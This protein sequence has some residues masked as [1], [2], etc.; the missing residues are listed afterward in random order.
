MK[1]ILCL[2]LLLYLLVSYLP[3]PKPLE[4]S[5]QKP[6]DTC[7]WD[8]WPQPFTT[9]L[10]SVCVHWSVDSRGALVGKLP[11]GSRWVAG[12]AVIPVLANNRCGE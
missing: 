4:S 6:V 7:W 1:I 3:G 9:C 5:L 2:C 12:S 8:G 10:Q 11:Q